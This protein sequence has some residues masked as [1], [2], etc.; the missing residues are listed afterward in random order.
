MIFMN[1]KDK[2]KMKISNTESFA[3][4][5]LKSAPKVNSFK[6]LR[7]SRFL[8]G[9]IPLVENRPNAMFTLTKVTFY[10]KKSKR[11]EQSLYWK[12]PSSNVMQK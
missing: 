6:C 2:F 8:Y 10:L 7:L 12:V 11:N 3:N 5:F 9:S 4:K 1:F